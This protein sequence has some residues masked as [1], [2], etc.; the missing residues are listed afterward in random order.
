MHTA[1]ASL[2]VSAGVCGKIHSDSFAEKR[3]NIS[4]KDYALGLITQGLTKTNGEHPEEEVG[5]FN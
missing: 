2:K 4:Y 3:K 5:K 1:D